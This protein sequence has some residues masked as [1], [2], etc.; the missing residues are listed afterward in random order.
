MKSY[1]S[2]T[3]GLQLRHLNADLTSNNCLFG[4]VKLTKK[5]DPDKYKYSVYG[6]GSVSCSKFSFTDESIGKKIIIFGVVNKNKDILSLG[7]EPTQG[8]D[9]ATLKVEAKYPTDVTQRNKWLL[10][11]QHYNGCNSC[12]YV[13]TTKIY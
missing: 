3:L 7:E 2:Y 8:V 4:Y 11:S 9:G 13:N 5:A 6:I 1:I 12:L 10:L